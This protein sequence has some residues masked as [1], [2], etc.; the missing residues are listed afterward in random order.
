[1]ATTESFLSQLEKAAS[2]QSLDI[3]EFSTMLEDISIEDPIEEEE[4]VEENN[5]VIAELSNGSDSGSDSI[6]GEP[7]DATG[8]EA[9]SETDNVN[10]LQAMNELQ[11]LFENIAGVP[12]EEEK[13][14]IVEELVVEEVV[15]EVVEKV[16]PTIVIDPAVLE[17]AAV[18]L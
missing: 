12:I 13:E 15:E 2:G 16:K 9:I 3:V 8:M 18:E 1:M 4:I 17:E 6:M 7:E 11:S 10:V 14:E 5:P